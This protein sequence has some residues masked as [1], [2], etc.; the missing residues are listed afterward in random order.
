M[1]ERTWDQGLARA[2]E[3]AGDPPRWW[4]RDRSGVVGGQVAQDRCRTGL[5]GAVL[6]GRPLVSD[7]GGDGVDVLEGAL[8]AAFQRGADLGVETLNGEGESGAGHVGLPVSVAGPTA[9]AGQTG[10]GNGIITHAGAADVGR[11][12]YRRCA[13]TA[14]ADGAMY[15][16][17]ARGSQNQD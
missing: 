16:L 5:E 4:A 11:R 3:G 6:A 1:R 12:L 9:R 7:P 8:I 13:V 14:V 15:A 17:N 10:Q 2:D